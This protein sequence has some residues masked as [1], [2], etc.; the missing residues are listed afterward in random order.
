[1]IGKQSLLPVA[2][3]AESQWAEA[4]SS[5]KLIAPEKIFCFSSVFFK[6]EFLCLQFFK[7]ERESRNKTKHRRTVVRAQDQRLPKPVE[8]GLELRAEHV[9]EVRPLF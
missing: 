2:A 5:T 6:S 8:R 7:R 4:M 9:N 1:M 3:L